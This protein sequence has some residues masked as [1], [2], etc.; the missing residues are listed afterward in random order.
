[1]RWKHSALGTSIDDLDVCIVEPSRFHL[2]LVRQMI[3]H[4][5]VDVVRIHE[6]ASQ[7]L[8]DLVGH[9]AKMVVVDADLPEPVSVQRFVR[10]L[11][12]VTL[13]PLCYVPIV[14][15]MSRPTERRVHDILACGVHNL[16]VK[17]FSLEQLRVRIARVLED[18]RELV[19]EGE[20]YVLEGMRE[21]LASRRSKIDLPALASVL[22]RTT[23]DR[24]SAAQAVIDS[25]LFPV[26]AVSRA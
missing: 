5:Q 9:P 12:H 11:R 20:H 17:P 6:E 18:R 21:R 1:M 16:V 19:L 23:G 24:T 13:Q 22:G 14:V 3:L 7:A 15:T 10:A 26:P 4:M 2:S 25:I 8:L